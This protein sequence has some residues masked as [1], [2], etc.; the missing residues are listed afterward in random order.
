MP[1]NKTPDLFPQRS[2]AQNKNHRCLQCST[3]LPA[4]QRSFRRRIK[5]TLVRLGTLGFM[6]LLCIELIIRRYFRH[7]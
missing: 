6:Q 2:G 4:W 1:K 7:D 3:F 5:Q